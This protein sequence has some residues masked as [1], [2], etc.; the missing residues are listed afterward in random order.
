MN[1]LLCKLLFYQLQ[2]IG[3]FSE[4]VTTPAASMRSAGVI[5]TY[6]RWLEESLNLLK[7]NGYIAY[8]GYTVTLLTDQRPDGRTVWNEWNTHKRL[9]PNGELAQAELAEATIKAMPSILK[10]ERPATDIVFPDSSMRLV[11]GVYKHNP[12]ADYFN[13]VLADSAAAYLKA[14]LTEHPDARIRLIE[15]GAGTGGTSA[16]LFTKLKPFAKQIAEYC[17]TD[18]SKAFLMHAEQ[19]YGPDVPY[20]TTALFN[21]EE[22]CESQNIKTG[23]YDIV[24]AANVLHATKNIGLTLRRLKALLKYNGMI[25]INEISDRSVF[26]HLTFGLLD[27]WWSYEDAELRI[28]GSP[29]LYP[30]SWERVLHSEGYRAVCFPAETAHDLGQQIIAA[31]SDGLVRMQGIRDGRKPYAAPAEVFRKP[32]QPVSRSRA[33]E[34]HQA[35]KADGESVVSHVRSVIKTSIADVL[36]MKEEDIQEELNFSE[37]GIDSILAVNVINEINKRLN[38]TLQ[39]TILFDYYHVKLLTGYISAEYE[40]I[41]ASSLETER[42]KIRPALQ[43]ERSAEKPLQT[44][45]KENGYQK[46]KQERMPL[47]FAKSDDSGM[48]RVVIDRPGGIEDLTIARSEVPETKD[49][50]VQIAVR[51]FSLNFGD[52]LCVRGLYPTMPPYPFTPGFEASGVVI[53]TGRHVT[54]VIPG[55]EVIVGMGEEFGSQANLIT[56]KEHQVYHKPAR[57]TFEE[58]CAL[59]T[60]AVTMIDAFRKAGLKKGEKILIQTATGGTGLIA[61]QMARHIGAEI[62]ATAGSQKKIEYLHSLG[63]RNTICYLEEDF[64]T[65]IMRMTGGR[66]VDV[67]INTLA[68]DAMQKGM[69][70]LAPGGRYIEIAMTALKS[71]KSVDLS[72]LH[73]N[74]SFHSVDLRKLSLQNPDQVKDYQLELQRLAEEG[75]I[76]PVISKIFSFED[77]KEAYHCLDDRGNIGKIV[78]SVSEPYQMTYRPEQKDPAD[79]VK[80]AAVLHEKEPIAIIGMSGRFAESENLHEFWEH[81]AAGRDLIKK[82]DRWDVSDSQC[83]YGSFIEDIECFDP[84]FFHISGREATYM[85]PQQRLFLEESWKALEDAGYAGDSVRGRECGVYAGSCG[86]DYQAIFKQQGP[87]QAFWGNHNSVTPARIAYHLNLQGPAITVDT[88]CSSS[89]TAIHLACQGLW[90]KETEMAVAGGVFIQSTPAFYQ[91]SNKANMLSP[92]GRCHTFDQSADGFVPGEGVGAVVLKRLSDAVSDGDHVYGVIK[93]SAMNQDGA[94]NGITAPSALSQERLERHVYDTFHIDPETIQMVEAHGTGTALGD[95][96]E[97]GALTRAFRRY[98]DKKGYCAIGSV[99]TNL[100]HAAAAAGMAGLFKILLSLKHRQIPASLHFHQANQHIQFA[101]SPFFVNEKL[102]PWERNPD[103]PRRAAIS[104]FGFSGTNAHLVIE[105]APQTVRRSPAKPVCLIP[106]SAR[107]ERQLEIQAERLLDSLS[108]NKDS[109]LGNISYTLLLGRKHLHHRF[110]CIVSSADELKRVLSEWLVKRELPGVFVSNLKDQKPAEEAGMKTFGMECIEQCRSAASPAQYRESLAHIADLFCRGYDLPFTRLFDGG[111]YYKTPLPAYPFLKERYWAADVNSSLPGQAMKKSETQTVLPSSPQP[112]H[113]GL[114]S[115]TPLTE[116]EM[117]AF[118]PETLQKPIV[119]QPLD[120]TVSVQQPE[121]AVSED[122]RTLLEELRTSLADILFL[123]PE[124]IDADEPFIDMGL[125]SIIG[126]EWIQTVNKTYH[127]EITANKVYEHPTLEELAEY[128]A[129]QIKKPE[130]AEAE[131]TAVRP[132]IPEAETPLAGIS[133]GTLRKELKESL[134]DILFLKPEDIDEHEAFIEMGLDSIIGVEWVQSINKTYQASITANLVYEY[135]TIA[136]L[137]GYLTGSV[138]KDTEEVHGEHTKQNDISEETDDQEP[139]ELICL[140]PGGKGRPIFWFHSALGAVELYQP[141]AERTGRPFY[142]IQARGWMT[143]REPIRGIKNMAEYYVKLIRTVQ[144]RG[145]YDVGGY[146]LGGMLAYEVTRQLQLAGETVESI[147]M[148]DSFDSAG[149]RE[150]NIPDELFDKNMM[151]QTVNMALFAPIYQHPER[152]SE[153]LIH[154]DELD[155]DLHEDI[156]LEQL[157]AKAKQ[158]GLTKTDALV[159]NLIRQNI[160]V[161][162]AYEITDYELLPLPDPNGVT[163]Y[164]FRNKNGIF[165]GELDPY[166]TIRAD[167]LSADFVNYWSQWEEHMTNIAIMDVAV[168]NHMTL[169]AEDSTAET[170]SEFCGVLYSADGMTEHSFLQLQEKILNVHG[171]KLKQPAKT[172]P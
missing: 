50:E 24:I 21:A 18:V 6:G 15:V 61:V 53:K 160:N 163:C 95:P 25:L 169:L 4:P 34:E 99:K 151:L 57:L 124:D 125:D 14:Y 83:Q 2:S 138:Q 94:T 110:A 30:K 172:R 55:D 101:D 58:A 111:Q 102:I 146:S 93:G 68:G 164:Y 130:Y 64:E 148:L 66:G 11:E 92:T 115:L 126:V 129:G 89:L 157:I 139:P 116:I 35:V 150:I 1:S 77:I 113:E 109:D 165:L 166:F 153:T 20:L 156:F 145:P 78:I 135:P 71:A 5:G 100:G 44:E 105:E 26:T 12:V 118:E 136:T 127:T 121:K 108:K 98:T 69:N 155:A 132:Q 29:G 49:D 28:P 40:T 45:R 42:A 60:V 170:I 168:S 149:A 56:C 167:I 9:L 76:Q 80:S 123:S 70:C 90:T 32:A 112:E 59:P 131:E 19:E 152:I 87:A 67:V 73:N 47:S 133:D 8:D 144:P 88:A 43:E 74:Q 51:A 27:G 84:V 137:A 91:S 52:L 106:L 38:L 143:D 96:I 79:T 120:C 48:F 36:K 85:D 41:I 161:Q 97:F 134:A 122:N 65:E 154:R 158:R 31:E 107:T 62:Y 162:D 75:V 114:I 10:G 82:A 54:S 119:L 46:P 142:G 39:T 72:V 171:E 86:G 3:F 22:P 147:V 140:N 81:L 33:P 23:V 117:R 63:V 16:M 128:I 103:T 104:S 13:E 17:Y 141:V 7:E 37:Y 159:K